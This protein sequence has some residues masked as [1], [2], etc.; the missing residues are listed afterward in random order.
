M[1]P[2][3]GN[4]WARAWDGLRRRGSSCIGGTA[5]LDSA[6]DYIRNFGPGCGLIRPHPVS[7]NQ[8]SNALRM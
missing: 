4:G 1:I 6:I 8:S 2:A 7:Y 3:A 5:M